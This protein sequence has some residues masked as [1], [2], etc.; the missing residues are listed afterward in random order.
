MAGCTRGV[1]SE[2]NLQEWTQSIKEKKPSRTGEEVPTIG[3]FKVF[4]YE[5][6]M[7]G[8][9]PVGEE[10]YVTPNTE[11]GKLRN[12]FSFPV[13]MTHSTVSIR[14]DPNRIRQPLESFPL[15]GLKMV[16]TI[17][18]GN[19]TALIM[20]PDKVV[21]KVNPGQYL[22]QQD[23]RVLYVRPGEV[24]LLE[25]VP[26]GAGGWAEREASIVIE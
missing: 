25:L 14:P 23:G 13:D 20:A 4:S 11:A 19:R 24:V 26:D 1:T 10:P 17:G 21:Y 7:T 12:P 9:T 2:P 15:D 3:K 5:D 22:G 16:G 18:P 6:H 8:P